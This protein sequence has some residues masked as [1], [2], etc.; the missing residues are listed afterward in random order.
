MFINFIKFFVIFF[1]ISCV[2]HQKETAAINVA[3]ET[4][5]CGYNPEDY[6]CNFTYFDQND[7]KISL[8]DFKGK[9]ILLDFSTIWCYWCNVAAMEEGDIVSN[10]GDKDFVWIT[11]LIEDSNGDR[12][13]CSDLK[14]WID[15]HSITSPVLSGTTDILDYEDDGIDVGYRNGG[16]P[17][18]VVIS[19]DMIIK[20]YIYGWSKEKIMLSLDKELK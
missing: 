16:W 7:K 10:Y 14:L 2:S 19:K 8:H 17:S 18:F 3:Q 5:E 9:V 15:K 4:I 6:A 20:E 11:V 12:P 1:L 13:S